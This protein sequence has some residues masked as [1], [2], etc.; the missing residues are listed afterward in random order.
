MREWSGTSLVLLLVIGCAIIRD[1][2]AQEQYDM[3]RSRESVAEA[4]ARLYN[5]GGY[6]TYEDN[7]PRYDSKDPEAYRY[8]PKPQHY[9]SNYNIMESR[10]REI[11]AEFMYWY[12]DK[13]GDNNYGDYQTDIH[14]SMP[15][16]HKNFNFQLPFFG[17]RFNYTRL[18]MNG[19][20]EFSDPPE[21]Y[22]YPLNFPISD[23]PK[24]ND[25][26][27]IGPFFS[28]C[29]IGNVKPTDSDQRKPGVY[30]RMERDLQKRTDQFGVEMRERLMWDIREGVVGADS[31]EPKHAVI[32]TWKNMSF[33]GGIDVS[34][35]KTNTFQLVLATDEVYTYAM[36]NY[37]NLQWSSH[38]E[39]G[40]D[41]TGGEGGTPAYVGFNAG[42]GTGAY[43][44]YPYSQQMTIRDLPS[45]G[46][47]N[48]FPGRHIFRI[49]EKIMLGNCNKDISGTDLPLVF[50]PESGNMLGGTVVNITGPCFQPNDK[51]ICRFETEEVVGTVVDT[52]RAIC[53]QPF[54]KMEGYIR[55]AVAINEGGFNWK[56]RYF[57]ETPATATKKIFFEDNRMVF[58][59]A[60]EEIKISWNAYNLT[61]NLNALVQISLWG[62]RETIIRPE[63]E[64]I[65][66]I[67]D[68]TVNNGRYTITP[69]NFRDRMNVRNNDMQFGFLQI[70]LTNPHNYNDLA[71][72]PVLWSEP[73]P[74][75]WYFNP[76]W[77]RMYGQ[78]WPKR[79]CDQWIERDRY[80]KNFAHEVSLCPCTLEHAL[81][82]KGRFL[83]DQHCDMNVAPS[84]I[85]NKGAIH[86]VTTGSPNNEGAEQQCCYDRNHMLMLSYDQK[87]G[88]RPRRSH[89]LGLLP[90][91]EANK[92]P[93]LSHWYHDMT[94]L[95][96]CC[97]WQ[98]EQSV[99]CETYRFELRPSQDCIA[100][101]AP[102]VATV[103]GDPHIVTFDGLEYTFN[104]QG[105]FVLVKVDDNKHKLDI[106]GR[107]KQVP[108]N[109]YGEVRAT[110]L[111][112][113]AAQCNSS[114][115][116][117][118]KLRP[119][120]SQWRY[121]LD[122]MVGGRKVYFDRQSLKYQ[123]FGNI[124][125]YTPPYILNQSE[126]VIM[127]DTGAGIEVLERNGFMSVRVY[128]PWTYMNKTRGLLGNW[129]YD[130][131]DD[132]TNPD[133]TVA[134]VTISGDKQDQ[135]REVDLNFAM[136]WMVSRKSDEKTGRGVS[137][138]QPEYGLDSVGYNG[139]GTFQP[140][141][142]RNINDILPNNRSIDKQRAQDL[143]GDC[144]QC[145]Y[146]YALTLNRD[147][148][149]TTK[150]FYDS[151]TH[152]RETN[153]RII[154]SCGI[155]ETP[156]FGMK[157]NFLFVPGT[158]V[159]FQCNEHFV[160]I[161][162]ARRICMPDGRWDVPIY[163][164]TEC[165]RQIEYAQRVAW[166]AIGI[167]VSIGLP[168]SLLALVIWFLMRG[169]G[170]ESGSYLARLPW[171]SSYSSQQ[172][173]QRQQQQQQQMQDDASSP[174]LQ[175]QEQKQ[176]IQE[177]DS[178][179]PNSDPAAKLDS[180]RQRRR[181]E[182][183]YRTNEPL[184]G[185]PDIEFE[186]KEWDLK[187]N[188]LPAALRRPASNRPSPVNVVD[189]ASINSS[190]EM[191]QAAA[192]SVSS[193]R[194]QQQQRPMDA[195]GLGIPAA[196]P[197]VPGT[198]GL[199]QFASIKPSA[200]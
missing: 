198:M 77:T 188:D 16:L 164:Y 148:A 39:A 4:S 123:H 140:E 114:Q 118:V 15:Q 180:L 95:H 191:S 57:V 115:T 63:L 149:V 49:D 194:P 179:S 25:P 69:Q 136:K 109:I 125:V 108:E 1:N 14:N 55:L 66:M 144:Y 145:Q 96:T 173:Q 171:G 11:R 137:L 62:Y 163:G 124:V 162:D 182:G 150:D 169:S 166:K 88:S 127:F 129:S 120:H 181:Y 170:S 30:F 172:Q 50:A 183:V 102:A 138:F 94:A 98:E 54:V 28:K 26:S 174:S 35:Y 23:W 199:A 40:G 105:E 3:Q 64:F 185:K 52:S 81:N 73:I 32:V 19:F 159:T 156:R 59:R 31:F 190:P 89:N 196:S 10:L 36:F 75:A 167:I 175:L 177:T 113:V 117:E 61:S 33:A 128:L 122:V 7:Y 68:S 160:L 13:G 17:F 24:S 72:T 112:A 97:F 121:H 18:S 9:P 76:Q 178:S 37:L 130:I 104:R 142:R 165:L 135:F 2:A 143:C 41:T 134:P 103:F 186:D 132:F 200:V 93:T 100:Y 82:D 158:K 22:T 44:Y 99:G 147:M 152:I 107:F 71:L 20:L 155:L 197:Y 47:A 8:A 85:Y 60:P 74:L 79:L 43:S 184:P 195:P 101:Q 116:V 126:V 187:E 42:N 92:V 58:E 168:V 111:T 53:I 189:Q 106:Q 29:R 151:F 78:N 45:R 21:H 87:W 110:Q 139:N 153:Q 84:C 48:G 91:N 34:L 154:I 192:S 80:L 86:C 90:W 161:G 146:D 141:W 67:E 5:P 131:L 27:F 133:G 51:V 70:N 46:W 38:T 12:F 157:S 119:T 193:R 65:D 83:P 6:N 56:G 176:P